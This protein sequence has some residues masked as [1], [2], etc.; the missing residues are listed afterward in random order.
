MLIP[1]FRISFNRASDIATAMEVRCY[2]SSQKRSYLYSLEI[3]K[4]DYLYL[5]ALLPI[6]IFTFV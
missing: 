2:D 4:M 6:I 1:L 3:E 5:F